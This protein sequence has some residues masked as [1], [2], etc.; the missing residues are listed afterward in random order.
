MFNLYSKKN[1]KNDV[2]NYY[3]YIG[4]MYDSAN[5]FRRITLIR[6]LY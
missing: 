6:L 1:E 4:S 2:N 5:Y 3:P